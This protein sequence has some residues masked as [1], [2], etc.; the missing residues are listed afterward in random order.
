MKIALFENGVFDMTERIFTEKA[1]AEDN[2]FFNYN[3]K[4]YTVRDVQGNDISA[5]FK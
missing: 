1:N 2:Y 5:T 4:G 3:G